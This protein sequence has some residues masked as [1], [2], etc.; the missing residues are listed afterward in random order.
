MEIKTLNTSIHTS[1]RFNKCTS[2]KLE[3]LSNDN[4]VFNLPM[5][6]LLEE[7][8]L[9]ILILKNINF[10]INIPS[11]ICDTLK[12][13]EYSDNFILN[14]ISTKRL[15]TYKHLIIYRCIPGVFFINDS[16]HLKT[17]NIKDST[18]IFQS[19]RQQ[20][21]INTSHIKIINR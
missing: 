17:I 20:Y 7:S 3:I 6:L 1:F 21:N 14:K 4:C 2:I 13:S 12:L 11:I 18:Y 9:N 16:Q 8:K 15:I 10:L 5:I 19:F